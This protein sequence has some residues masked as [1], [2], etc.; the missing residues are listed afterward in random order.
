MADNHPNMCY[1]VWVAVSVN[2]CV[3]GDGFVTLGLC[4]Y[5]LWMWFGWCNKVLERG[6]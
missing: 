1:F 2:S 4:F 6:N 3:D 5:V